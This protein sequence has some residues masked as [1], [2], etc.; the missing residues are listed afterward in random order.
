LFCFQATFSGVPYDQ[1]SDSFKYLDPA[2]RL[3]PLAKLTPETVT[4]WKNMA[5]TMCFYKLLTNSHLKEALLPVPVLLERLKKS[6]QNLA[7][8]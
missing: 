1:L 8:S 2:T 5:S 4:Y 3:V 7:Q 6:H